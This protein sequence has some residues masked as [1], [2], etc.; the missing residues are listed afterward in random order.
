MTPRIVLTIVLAAAALSA[1]AHDRYAPYLQKQVLLAVADC[2]TEACV[3]SALAGAP[4]LDAP[5]RMVA[6]S[7]LYA[8]KSPRADQ[9]LIEAIP[10]DPVAFWFAYEVTTTGTKDFRAV[11]DLYYLYFGAAASAVARRGTGMREF[12]IARSFADG[13]VAALYREEVERLRKRRPKTYCA[14]WKKLHA[15]VQAMLPPCG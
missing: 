14:T 10:A 13:E 4:Y 9:R 8:L 7:K 2:R 15:E 12:L 5:L 6:A 3:E 1:A 11:S